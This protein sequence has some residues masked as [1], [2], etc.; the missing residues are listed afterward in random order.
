M[1]IK[2]RI[3]RV[4]FANFF[5]ASGFDYENI[6]FIDES[7]IK[8]T[9]NEPLSWQLKVPSLEKRGLVG[10]YSHLLAVH[11]SGR[12]SRRGATKLIIFN[13]NMNARGSLI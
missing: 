7:T 6:I 2:N 3:E 9:K 12:I 5:L 1:K 11:V 8:A 13:E 4:I 10:R